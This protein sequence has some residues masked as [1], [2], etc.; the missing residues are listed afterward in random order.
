LSGS[1][2]KELRYFKKSLKEA[3]VDLED[4]TGM[5]NSFDGDLVNWGRIPTPCQAR[6]LIDNQK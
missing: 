2:T 3:L 5:K 1:K 6:H 4:V